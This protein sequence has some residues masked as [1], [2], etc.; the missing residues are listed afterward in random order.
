[1]LALGAR[2]DARSESAMKP[3]ITKQ[4]VVKKPKTFWMRVRVLNIFSM[5]KLL[6]HSVQLPELL[7]SWWLYRQRGRIAAI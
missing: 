3:A 6:V 7:S 1:M 2:G 5:A 4:T